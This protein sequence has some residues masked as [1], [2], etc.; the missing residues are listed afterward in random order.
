MT[1]HVKTEDGDEPDDDDDDDED[2]VKMD[3]K[4]TTLDKGWL[5]SASCNKTVDCGEL[6]LAPRGLLEIVATYL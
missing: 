2:D 5:W 6:E 1:A 4:C 3:V